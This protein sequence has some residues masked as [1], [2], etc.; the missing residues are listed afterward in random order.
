MKRNPTFKGVDM[1]PTPSPGKVQAARIIALPTAAPSPVRN[2][3]R[4]RRPKTVIPIG[5]AIEA[6]NK[7]RAL[8]LK[9][10]AEAMF[11]ETQARYVAMLRGQLHSM[12]AET[13][14]SYA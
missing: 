3:R 13:G 4:G 7:E 1:N 10:S 6:R 12:I 9:I 5:P 2:S 11:A 8:R 14:A